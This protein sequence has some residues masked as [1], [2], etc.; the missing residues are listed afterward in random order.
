MLNVVEVNNVAT[1]QAGDQE[2]FGRLIEPYRRELLVHCY[3]MLGSL[4]EAEDLVQETLLRAWRRLDSFQRH[5]SFRAWLY[6]IATNA[7]LDTLDKR[8]RRTLPAAIY[9]A[10]DPHE[11]IASPIEEPIWLEPFPDEW[12][13]QEAENPEAIYTRRESVTLAFLVALQQLLPRQ[14]AV[15]ILRDVLDWNAKEVAGVLGLTLPA[16]NSALHRA[17][18]T[19]AKQHSANGREAA[20]RLSEDEVTRKLLNDYVAAWE[21]ADINKLI[22]LLKEDA[23]F[24]M[25]PIP[26]WYQGRDAIRTFIVNEILSNDA[27]GGGRRLIRTRAN[28]QVAVAIYHCA[29]AGEPY[30]AFALQVLTIDVSSEQ[31]SRITNFL[32][33]KLFARFGLP[34]EIKP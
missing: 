14:R 6:K 33:L 32:N 13:G 21:A 2:A 27:R 7:C 19:I 20:K 8:P 15:L 5:V 10:S 1:A 22:A 24:T 25:P 18:T 11:P 29:N 3:R 23:T 9:S 30:Q 28:G 26:T 31:I 16:V 12:L 4:Q 34:L 17:R